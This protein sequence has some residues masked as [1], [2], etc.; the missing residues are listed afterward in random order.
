MTNPYS[1]NGSM[2][3]G[4]GDDTKVNKLVMKSCNS[5]LY[6]ANSFSVNQKMLPKFLNSVY[7]SAVITYFYL[8]NIFQLPQIQR[9]SSGLLHHVVCF[10]LLSSALK[11][12]AV[13]SS[14]QESGWASEP[15][16]M[17]WQ[18]EKLS[19]FWKLEPC[20]PACNPD[21]LLTE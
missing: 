19:L 4:G 9:A 18:Q 6:F 17:W 13:C 15:I 10:M 21:I 8:I 2:R 1:Q 5:I 16:L 14:E 20:H 3:G 11:T 12:E 7:T